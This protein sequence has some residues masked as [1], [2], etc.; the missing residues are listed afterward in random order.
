M[1]RFI[2]GHLNFNM[3][4]VFSFVLLA[5]VLVTGSSTSFS[6]KIAHDGKK[7][8]FVA[9]A[10]EHSPIEALPSCYESGIVF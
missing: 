10:Y 8:T 7:S 1:S 6:A 3:I 4:F 5:S 9:A 2:I